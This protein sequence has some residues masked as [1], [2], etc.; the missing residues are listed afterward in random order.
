MAEETGLR[1]TV[2]NALGS[3]LRDAPGGAVYEIRDYLVEVIG[4]ELQP[5]D[6]AADVLWVPVGELDDYPLV[7][8][9]LESLREW[10][11]LLPHSPPQPPRS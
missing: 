6:D 3:V 11:A 5:G 1:V 4:G 2:G 9:L 7:E 10:G 8:G